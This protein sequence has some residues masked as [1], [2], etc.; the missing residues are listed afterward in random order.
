MASWE[1][2][3]SWV[4]VGS[5]PLAINESGQRW[6]TVFNHLKTLLGDINKLQRDIERA[7][8]AGNTADA[9]TEL[10]YHISTA[11]QKVIDKHHDIATGL[12]A[13]ADHLN[14]AT[15]NLRV[16]SYI[17]QEAFD[18]RKA[19]ALSGQLTAY[20]PNEF[21][22]RM[23]W[24]SLGV[25][26][27]GGEAEVGMN[28]G[29]RF[30][31]AYHSFM[32]TADKA[33]LSLMEQY[34]GD[35]K[36]IGEG[37]KVP[38]PQ[39]PGAGGARTGAG[40]GAGA[41][42]IPSG[43]LG[44]GVSTPTMPMAGMTPNLASTPLSTTGLDA[45]TLPSDLGNTGLS[46]ADLGS[47]GLGSSGLGASGLGSSGLGKLGGSGLAGMGP[48]GAGG[49]GAGGLGTG[50]GPSVSP[51]EM[52][53][54]TPGSLAGGGLGGGAAGLAGA[55]AGASTMG[56]MPGGAG[57]GM[58]TDPGG[59]TETR[60]IEDDKNIFGPRIGDRDLPGDVIG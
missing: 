34:K 35:A 47:S 25:D 30:W 55:G 58:P 42:D 4:Y 12:L 44:T 45:S 14:A 3:V 56:M 41:K 38:S 9:L 16:P 59:Q 18:R 29:Q 49:L 46:G 50:L 60:L 15:P 27:T 13:A 20:R 54:E 8:W 33:R 51:E 19:F 39:V 22:E 11:A 36:T 31:Y 10:L 24:I 6:Q 52:I 28:I 26:P 48:L 43:S 2:N 1:D 37:E 21:Y 32:E 57:A 40:A 5:S 7:G 23:P 17:E 53:G